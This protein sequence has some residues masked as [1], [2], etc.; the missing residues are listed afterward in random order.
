MH[1]PDTGQ[2]ETCEDPYNNYKIVQKVFHPSG[3]EPAK[4]KTVV[5]GVIHYTTQP[6]L[7]LITRTDEVDRREDSVKKRE[8]GRKRL[9]FQKARSR[10]PGD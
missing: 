1:F 10:K 4:F 3:L 2:G 6:V 8:N 7:A 5:H 9:D